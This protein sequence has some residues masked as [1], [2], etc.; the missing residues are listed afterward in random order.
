MATSAARFAPAGPSTAE[1]SRAPR[2][3]TARDAW[4]GGTRLRGPRGA[5]RRAPARLAAVSQAA[6]NDGEQHK[7]VWLGWTPPA[8]P[9]REA[10]PRSA[11]FT[12]AAASSPPAS[13]YPSTSPQSPGT[14]RLSQTLRNLGGKVRGGVAA[15]RLPVLKPKEGKSVFERSGGFVYIRNFFSPR[16]YQLLL[17]ECEM[18]RKDIGA[19]RR[20]CARQ[21]LGTMVAPDHLVHRAFMNQRVAERISG[22]VGQSVFPAD[23]PVEYRVYPGGSSMEWHQDVALYTEPQYELVF[24]LENTSDSQT[25]WQDGDGHRRG[26]WTEPNSIIMVKAESVVHRVTPINTGERSIVK[27]VYTTTLDKTE[28]YY[29][30]LL[31]YS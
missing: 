11:P 23:V 31:T 13:G 17:D 2:A 14:A 28:E 25:Q 6:G 19:E 30:N 12:N 22:L 18:L 1:A 10:T 3:A 4:R 5:A 29:D 21:R 7:H 27:F 9:R 16:D 24:T 20:A 8:A 15:P 26:G